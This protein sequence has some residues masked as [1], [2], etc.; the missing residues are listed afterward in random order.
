MA[1][2]ETVMKKV[3]VTSLLAVMV[4]LHYEYSSAAVDLEKT[5]SS[6]KTAFVVVIDSTADQAEQAKALVKETRK[7]VPQ[8]EMVILDRSA[9]ENA[10]FVAKYRLQAAPVPLILV[11]VKGGIIVGSVPAENASTDKLV[12][13]IPSPKK[14]EVIKAIQE[15]KS[16]FIMAH[17]KGMKS[18]GDISDRCTKACQQMDNKSVLVKVDMDDKAEAEFLTLLNIDPALAEPVTIVTNARGQITNTYN[19]LMNVEDLVQAA[20]KRAGGCCPSTPTSGAKKDCP[21]QK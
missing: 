6:G 15:G 7:K 8:S 18:T 12:K 11:A 19:G 5:T 17:K 20:T 14:L 3:F 9:A 2:K 10:D 16:V 1:K 21:P 4:L 13:M